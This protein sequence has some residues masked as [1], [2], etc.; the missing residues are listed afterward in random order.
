M[1]SGYQH[2]QIMAAL[3]ENEFVVGY[4]PFANENGVAMGAIGAISNEGRDHA[5][6]GGLTSAI[7][8]K[9]LYDGRGSTLVVF[10]QDFYMQLLD[11]YLLGA[12]VD[13]VLSKQSLSF[14][15]ICVFDNQPGFFVE[16]VGCLPV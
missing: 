3:N 4:P 11:A 7:A 10:A 12:L 2:H 13:T 15:S 14:D 8:T 16:R 5:C 1:N 9:A 6:R